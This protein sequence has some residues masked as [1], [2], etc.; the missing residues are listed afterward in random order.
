MK[1]KFYLARP[2]SK[3]ETTIFAW[4]SY[5]A[6]RVKVYTGE[7]IKP[8]YWNKE[9]H[10][11]RQS[12]KFKEFPEFNRRL[13]DI[14]SDINK[15]FLNYRNEHGSAPDPTTLKIVLDNA[16]GRKAQVK[17]SFLE[18]LADLIKRQKEGLRINPKT[19]KPIISA[20]AKHYKHTLNSI[21]DFAAKTGKKVDWKQIDLSFYN[22]YTKYLTQNN[23]A[24][25][26]IGG[27]IQR[28]KAVL[29]EAAAMHYD[30]NPDY[31]SRY[32]SR[33][34]EVADNICLT[35]E[36]LHALEAL[37]L[38]KNKRLEAVRD[39]FVIGCHTGLRYSDFS[40]LK[41]SDINHGFIKI[42]QAKTGNPITIPV[43]P[44]VQ[45]IIDR[46]DGELPASISNQKTNAYLKEV[47]EM[48]E[49][50]QAK[51]SKQTTKGGVKVAVTFKRC[52]MLSTHTARRT[53]ATLQYLKGVPSITIMA[54]TGHKTEKDFLKYIKVTNDG[55]AQKIKELW[56]DEARAQMK[57]V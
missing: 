12:P 22:D 51:T 2:E 23:I 32:F 21:K 37:D 48:V 27:H 49:S 3:Q 43:H 52:E 44:A 9:T 10:E 14:K 54:I 31:K 36:E 15:A 42:T 46:Y 8:I 24:L 18:Y 13:A 30:V 17:L 20:T 29:N 40:T 56:A 57:A 38:S 45:K 39:L 7:S 47:G 28:I 53:F 50:M 25:N 35:Q 41:I 5:G 4:V 16:L 19:N 1:V 11:A 55:H 33:Q 6:N 34:S 26:T